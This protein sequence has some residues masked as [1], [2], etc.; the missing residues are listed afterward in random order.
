MIGIYPK[1]NRQNGWINKLIFYLY[2]FTQ[3]SFSLKDYDSER[4]DDNKQN[5]PYVLRSLQQHQQLLI[6]YVHHS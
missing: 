6:F 1:L 3:T 2:N 5:K 4:G